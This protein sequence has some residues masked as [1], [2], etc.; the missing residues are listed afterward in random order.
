MTTFGRPNATGRSSGRR[1]GKAAK[2]HRPPKD[3]PW[4]WLTRELVSSPAWRA[5][6]INCV[7]LLDFLMVEHMNHAGIENGNLQ[8]PYDQL[9]ER[10]LTRKL[11]RRATDEAKFLGLLRIVRGG[12]WAE[13]NRPST[14]RL[15][16]LADRDNN[17]PTDEWKGKTAEAIDT[18]K[19]DLA[20]RDQ[21][22]RARRQK[23][24]H[25]GTCTTTVVAL[26]PLRD[27]SQRDRR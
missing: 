25:G 10:G 14:Y 16:F 26:V 17:P 6:S 27:T 19:Q 13:T 9:E 12:R 20:Q 4:V 7:R 18:W 15:T 23:Q 24:I 1:T 22:R 5:R 11:I 8:A 2:A 3:E 21:A